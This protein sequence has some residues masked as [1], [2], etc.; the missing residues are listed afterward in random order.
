MKNLLALL[1]AALTL[2]FTP[3]LHAS[4]RRQSWDDA[5]NIADTLHAQME[6]VH[7]YKERF[8]DGPGLENEVQHLHMGLADLDERI[9]SR[10]GDPKDAVTKAHDL[11]NLMTTVQAEFRDRARRENTE[12]VVFHDEWRWK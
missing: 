5:A 6:K 9:Q 10:R 2:T 12:I 8:G 1:L 7:A 4:E 11:W 3:S